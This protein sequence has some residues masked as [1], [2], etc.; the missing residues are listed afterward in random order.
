MIKNL[1]LTFITILFSCKLLAQVGINTNDPK[2]TLD[3][4]S[5][6]NINDAAAGIISPRV[7][8]DYLITNNHLYTNDQIG[9][10]VYVY[11]VEEA[12]SR[13]S[14][15]STIGIKKDG[16]YYF[17]GIHWLLFVVPDEVRI[18]SEPWRVE[19]T[20]VEATQNTENIVQNAQVGIGFAKKI[21]E[22]AQF[23]VRSSNKGI[24]IPRMT[25]GERDVI[26]NPE[27]SLLIF[28]TD[29]SCFNFYKNNKW[30]SLC[31]DIG[32]SEVIVPNCNSAAF[33][34]AYKVGTVANSGNY[35]QITV[36]VVEAGDYSI[37][38][39]N[40]TAGFFFQKEGTF[41]NTG[42]YT[43]QI[44]VI[45][46]PA[47]AGNNT[48]TITIND[49]IIACNP[50][51]NVLPADVQFKDIVFVSA[52]QLKKRESSG[53]KAFNI[54]VNVVNPG[55]FNFSTNTVNGVTY[56]AEN[57]NLTT[58]GIRPVALYANGNPPANAGIFEYTITGSGYVGAT[59]KG[60]V[61]VIES[62][63]VISSISC[64]SATVKGTYNLNTPLTASN[65]IDIP[66][67]ASST[68]TYEISIESADNPG[69]SFSG[70][71]SITSTGTTSIRV[72]GIG[73]PTKAGTIPFTVTINGVTCTLNV[74]VVM[75]IKPILL[76]GDSFTQVRNALKN[77]QNF[78][79]D[80]KSKIESFTD[81]NIKLETG[82]INATKLKDY[83]NNQGVQVILIGWSWNPD[84]ACISILKDFVQKKKGFVYWVES[85]DDQSYI[86]SFIDQTYNGNV[87]MTEDEYYIYT[88]RVDSN[89]ASD[90]PFING[91]FGNVPN[92][93]LRS[94]DYPS[95][96]GI[97]PSTLPSSLKG[98]LNL[99]AN[100]TSSTTGVNSARTTF[101]YGEGFFMYPDWG[102]TNYADGVYYGTSSPIGTGS[103][104]FNGYQ[105][106]DG[107]SVGAKNVNNT[108]IANWIIF[109]NAMDHIFKYVQKNYDATIK[110]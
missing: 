13:N 83:I 43:I 80:G 26:A 107:T 2:A 8:L 84:A 41:P 88:A 54:T 49:K 96:I 45:G 37:L 6:N 108:S 104:T 63:A 71:G 76:V 24:L 60:S 29:S 77:I 109:G 74:N 38:V 10:I 62:K 52:D 59:A 100:N 12:A 68:G 81:A 82:S 32:Q 86:K 40:P 35:F 87:T 51:V 48:F 21:N 23:E 1:F 3:V 42:N 14:L 57:V 47:V 53:G 61:V 64:N 4:S 98:L 20:G 89:L 93:I 25:T 22:S 27:N 101:I 73:T 44:P 58:T 31:G 33:I 92:G 65:Y 75:P 19:E 70:S 99:P 69:F 50:V 95:W 9:V 91:V 102:M 79:V 106:W 11:D 94:D 90:N 16:Y 46:T 105:G 30:K 67:T 78:G 15:S 5:S 66:V 97:V 7:T 18:P 28:N 39:N 36:N 85:Q 56:S 103:G 34:G 17:D 110:L 55:Y 72:Y